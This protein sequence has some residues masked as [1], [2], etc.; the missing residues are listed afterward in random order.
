M[1]VFHRKSHIKEA[2]EGGKRAMKTRRLRCL[3][4]VIWVSICSNL[5][6]AA[7]RMVIPGGNTV[8]IKLYSRGLVVTGFEDSSSAREAG[9]KKGDVILAV[10]GEI[11]HTIQ[12]LRNSLGDHAVVLTVSRKGKEQNYKVEPDE[13]AEG[14]RIGVYVRDSMAGI[15]TVTYYDPEDSTFGALGHGVN[16]TDADVLLP[17]EAGVVVS[18]SVSDVKKGKCGDPGELKGSFDVH[19]ILGAVEK[20]TDLGIFGKL[21]SCPEGK[22]IPTAERHEIRTGAAAILSNIQGTE[23]RSYSVEILKIYT[24]DD[25]SGKDMLIQVK[26]DALL[27]KTGGIVQGMSGS[28]IIQNG[29]IVGAVT[30]VLVNDP[31]RGYGI[32]IE[33]MLSEAE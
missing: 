18:S 7:P 20:N 3:I 1:P 6:Y 4:L 11:V 2:S 22:A 33:N 12:N 13:T 21:R 27:E 28:P 24:N 17:L 9:L 25:G 30:H 14:R 26:D 5:V 32:S 19:R 16:D 23:T 29:K 10:D 31:T 15:G 8:G